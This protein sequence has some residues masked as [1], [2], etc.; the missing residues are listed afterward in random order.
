MKH[1]VIMENWR[2]FVNEDTQK[3]VLEEGIL[4]TLAGMMLVLNIGGK[5][6]QVE[7]NDVV[8]GYKQAR[9]EQMDDV[10][11][12]LKDVLE[13]AAYNVEVLGDDDGVVELGATA[14]LDSNTEAL[15]SSI[16]ND[17]TPDTGFPDDT[18]AESTQTL[19]VSVAINQMENAPTKEARNDW[20][21]KILDYHEKMGDGSNVPP[22]VVERAK[23]YLGK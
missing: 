12:E 9:A 11:L 4:S 20:A 18:G 22:N 23:F 2:R 8:D 7:L 3:Q 13:V 17:D 5:E 14:N 10:A 21:Q 1:K 19:N 6:V 16:I 15:M